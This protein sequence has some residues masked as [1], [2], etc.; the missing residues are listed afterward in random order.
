[1]VYFKNRRLNEGGVL[2]WVTRGISPRDQTHP[3]KGLSALEANIETL[4]HV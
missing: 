2:Y 4:P 1:M 3:S